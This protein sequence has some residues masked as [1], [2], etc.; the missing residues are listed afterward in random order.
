VFG[1][2][3]QHKTNVPLLK[4]LGNVRDSLD[5]ELIVLKVGMRIERDRSKEDDHRLFQFINKLNCEVGSRIVDG[6]LRAL[7]PVNHACSTWIKWACTA[8]G[9][10]AKHAFSEKIQ[11]LGSKTAALCLTL[12]EL[13]CNLQS[14]IKSDPLPN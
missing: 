1:I 4:S 12:V 8:N 14:E 10:S 9:Y 2:P 7:H 5:Q 6:S 11:F 3:S 13:I